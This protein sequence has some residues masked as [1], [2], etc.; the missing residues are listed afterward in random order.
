MCRDRNANPLS[1]PS[2][3]SKVSGK[4]QFLCIYHRSIINIKYIIIEYTQRVPDLVRILDTK[5]GTAEAERTL[6]RYR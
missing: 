5:D 6:L 4:R 3:T 2:I 1:A